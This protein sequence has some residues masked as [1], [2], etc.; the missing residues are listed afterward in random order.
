ML[1]KQQFL[2]FNTNL[3]LKMGNFFSRIFFTNTLFK[4]SP[5]F[6]TQK[7][8]YMGGIREGGGG[9]THIGEGCKEYSPKV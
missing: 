3:F 8:L 9:I 7:T 4:G 1:K 5:P 6:L 2:I